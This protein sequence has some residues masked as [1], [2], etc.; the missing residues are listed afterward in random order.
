MLRI[1]LN[2]KPALT[3]HQIPQTI[4]SEK[5]PFIVKA[6]NAAKAELIAFL[7]ADDEWLPNKTE[8]MAKCLKNH[9]EIKVLSSRYDVIDENSE[10]IENSGVTYLGKKEDGSIEYLSAE[11]F[12]GCSYVR[13]FSMCFT[14]DIKPYIKPIDVKDLLSHDWYICMLGCCYGKT[15]I[16]NKKLCHYRYHRDN[17]SLSAMNNGSGLISILASTKVK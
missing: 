5:T 17:V 9:P 16:L 12:I 11:S 4:R 13:G 14:A 6:I 3:T 2:A 15:A 8:I 10:I 7:D 1:S